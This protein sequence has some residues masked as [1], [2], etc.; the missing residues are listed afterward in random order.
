M[1]PRN[2]TLIAKAVRWQ[3][4]GIVLTVGIAGIVVQIVAAGEDVPVAAAVVVA[5]AADAE[6][7]AV[8]GVTAVDMVGMVVTAA[9]EDTN[10]GSLRFTKVKIPTLLATKREKGGAPR[11][12]RA[13]T[14]VAALFTCRDS[15]LLGKILLK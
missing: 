1:T 14:L 5:D 8:A 11:K 12:Y 9:A 3:A 10:R 7:G 6:A 15:F 2:R 4:A 13:A